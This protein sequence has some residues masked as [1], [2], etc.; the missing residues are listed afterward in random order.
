MNAEWKDMACPEYELLLED[1][2]SGKLSAEQARS[3]AVHVSSCAGCRATFEEASAGARL[4]HVALPTPDPGPQ[5]AHLVMAR[6]RTER[7]HAEQSSFWQPLISLAWKFAVTAAVAFLLLFAYDMRANQ[8]APDLSAASI[9]ATNNG[10]LFS[11]GLTESAPLP[12][13][14]DEVLVMVSETSTTNE[15]H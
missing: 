3:L 13:N 8:Q 14:R 7:E 11:A 2:L 10:D 12:S 6:I 15:Q 1:H 5:F 4:L 9:R